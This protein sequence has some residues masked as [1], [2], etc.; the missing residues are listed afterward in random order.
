MTCNN[1]YNPSCDSTCGCPQQ[2]KGSCVF[3]QGANLTC[4]DVTK[5]DDYD[6][7]LAS[8][9]TIVCN[10]VAP[11]GIQ[12]TLTGC[13]S[14][15]VT[16]TSSTNY[17]VCLSTA[18]QTQ[19]NSN[20]SSIATLSACAANTVKAITSSSLIIT[21]ASTNTCGRT[22]NIEVPVP[23]GTPI[24]D[25]IIYSDST[26]EEAN[27]GVGTDVVL[28]NSGNSIGS[29][30]LSNGLEVGDEIRWRANGQI[31]SDGNTVDILKYDFRNGLSPVGIITGA[32]F[33][34][35]STGGNETSW[36]MEG[37]ATVLDNTALNAELL[38]SVKLFRNGLANSNV[39]DTVRDLYIFNQTI[40]G[41]DLTQ[42]IIAIKY[43]RNIPN[44]FGP[45]NFARQLV[46]EIRKMI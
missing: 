20:T 13:D 46:V 39:S 19:I 37:T 24:V 27:R 3:Y 16:P 17:N 22:L 43:T 28:K 32:T 4:L 29:Y 10:L 5:G 38:V 6:S 45:T 25:G 26:K 21:T 15:T 30:Y 12:T 42:L 40:T 14:I 11:T 18:T 8:L 33:T 2:V 9:N 1:C 23:S 41:V 44:I 35:F 36:Q 31:D 34:G 7:I